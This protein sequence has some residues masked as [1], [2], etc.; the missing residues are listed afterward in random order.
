MFS[1]EVTEKQFESANSTH[2]L[3]SINEETCSLDKNTSVSS[4]CNWN[5]DA[6][7]SLGK[8]YI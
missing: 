5:K 8:L 7:I 1:M 2:Q 3:K 6:K 4:E